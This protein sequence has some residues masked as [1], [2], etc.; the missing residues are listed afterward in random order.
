[1]YLHKEKE[2]GLDLSLIPDSFW[3]VV[4]RCPNSEEL[5]FLLKDGTFSLDINEAVGLE[6]DWDQKK[7]KAKSFAGELAEILIDPLSS[8][9]SVHK[10]I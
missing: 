6:G 3:T 5:M 4:K 10:I 8:R 2:M 7:N 1:M 9:K